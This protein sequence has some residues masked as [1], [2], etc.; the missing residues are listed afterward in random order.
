MAERAGLRRA[1]EREMRR[2]LLEASRNGRTE[3]ATPSALVEPCSPRFFVHGIV[4]QV[5]SVPAA[6]VASKKEGLHLRHLA[7]RVM[8]LAPSPPGEGEGEAQIKFR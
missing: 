2:R 7:S 3:D 4:D 5:L 1:S 6:E 8:E